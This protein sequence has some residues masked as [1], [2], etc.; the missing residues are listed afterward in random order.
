MPGSGHPDNPDD[1]V[2]MRI[3]V[4]AVNLD[5]VWLLDESFAVQKRQL[6][7]VLPGFHLEGKSA[8]VVRR[9]A[10]ALTRVDVDD[11]DRS[12]LD[13][14]RTLGSTD[15]AADRPVS[16]QGLRAEVEDGSTV[17]GCQTQQC[18]GH[19]DE[20]THMGVVRAVEPN[21]PHIVLDG[22][23]LQ[24]RGH[25]THLMGLY[26][27]SSGG[28]KCRRVIKNDRTAIAGDRS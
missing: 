5:D 3:D 1:E 25:C 4:A 11:L 10:L 2:G 7:T 16:L 14:A 24:G 9:R 19:S 21:L 13:W 18:Y 27:V 17:T 8:G 26:H 28:R 15:C 23:A 22:S 6:D 12:A 20:P